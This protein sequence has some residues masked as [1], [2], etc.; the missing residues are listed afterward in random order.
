MLL[1][2]QL[3]AVNCGCWSNLIISPL[4]TMIVVACK[5]LLHNTEYGV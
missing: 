3:C 1:K 5:L 2:V 4:A